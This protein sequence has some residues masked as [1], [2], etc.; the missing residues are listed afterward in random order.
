RLRCQIGSTSRFFWCAPASRRGREP[1]RL[2]WP[3]P[4]TYQGSEDDLTSEAPTRA[5]IDEFVEQTKPLLEQMRR[6]HERRLLGIFP[7]RITDEF[8]S[9]LIKSCFYASMI[10]DE[11]RW[12]LVT[13]G[14]CGAEPK[15]PIAGL[16][17]PVPADPTAIAKLSHTV[18]DW[19]SL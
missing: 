13:V 9:E 6:L 2:V 17:P 7:Y 15:H 5:S 18:N 10:S 8:A 16:D 14:V 3:C 19:C 4:P 1:V 12:P 11:G